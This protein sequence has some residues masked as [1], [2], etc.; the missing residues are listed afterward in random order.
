MRRLLL[1]V[2]VLAALLL[3]GCTADPAPP[4]PT[5]DAARF[6]TS[7]A[8]AVVDAPGA[9]DRAVA[10]SRALF[11]SSPGVVLAPATDGAAQRRAAAEAERLHVPMLLVPG[12]A[13]TGSSAAPRPS[14]SSSD[15][16]AAVLREV[17][18]LGATWA[19]GFGARLPGIAARRAGAVPPLPASTGSMLAIATRA[20]ADTAALA[21]ARA[22]GARVVPASS[23][24]LNADAKVVAALADAED[25]RAVLVGSAFGARDDLA[26]SVTAARSGWTYA[27]G[28]QRAW[29]GSSLHIALYG[30]PGDPVLGALGQQGGPATISRVRALAAQYAP[31]TRRTVSPM[32]EVIATVA[33]G[34]PTGNGD[35]SGE[36]DPERLEPFVDASLAA[37][38]PVILDLQ[39]GRSDF[40]TQAKEY[41]SLLE[42]PGVG[43]ALDPE[44]RLGPKQKPLV[45]IGRVSAAEVNRTSAWLADL[46]EAKGLPPKPFVLHEFRLTMLQ[47]RQRIVVDRPQLD[48]LIHVD[49]Q[50][51]QPDKQATWRA[52][53]AGAPKV[54]WGWKN[55][56]R[57]D[58]PVLT[59]AQTIQQVH[60]TPDLIT[61]Q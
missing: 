40:L 26:W 11:A 22:A 51:S 35:Y 32:L 44:W 53:R 37:H 56:L 38:V 43:L 27:D 18:R 28:T 1:T 9:P 59:P 46:V 15:P 23:S 41:A 25:A 39:P 34:G 4:R 42:K 17:R 58:H 50:G 48:T 49:G 2:L 57:T 61:Y 19:A 47:D 3:A 14:A 7:R 52:V 20:S 12:G 29:G 33:S 60:P 31:L 54:G 36:I 13:G 8:T 16:A 10:A 5:E 6:A 45:Q 30:T 24:D 55:F 21:S